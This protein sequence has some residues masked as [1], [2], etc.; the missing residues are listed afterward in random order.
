M[1]ASFDL[2]VRIQR[3]VEVSRKTRHRRNWYKELMP[4]QHPDVCKKIQKFTF[5]RRF[6]RFFRT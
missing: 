1:K 3:N 5:L 4:K 2:E 6:L